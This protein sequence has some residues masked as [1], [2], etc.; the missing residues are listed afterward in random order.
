MQSIEPLPDF[1]LSS[2]KHHSMT[3]PDG[4]IISGA[5]TLESMALNFKLMLDPISFENKSVIDFGTWTGAFAVEAKKRGARE[6]TAVDHFVWQLPNVRK[7]FDFIVSSFGYDIRAIEKD[8]DASPLDLSDLGTFDVTLFLGVFY[9]LCDPI[10]ALREIAK[11][12]REVL[13]VESYCAD[14]DGSIPS[15]PPMMVFYPGSELV[16]DP[17]NWWGPNEACLREMLKTFGFRTV[18]SIVGTAKTRRIFF[19]Y[20]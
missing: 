16:G 11:M 1:V 17:S 14:G 7:T 6:V 10:A 3:L 19:A 15:H 9:H 18:K 20:K 2:P 5:K 4:R 8:L 12:T 13:V